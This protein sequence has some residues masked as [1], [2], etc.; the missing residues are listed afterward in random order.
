MHQVSEIFDKIGFGREKIEKV[1]RFREKNGTT[2]T[3]LV[4]LNDETDRI[5]MS[6]AE[7]RIKETA[8][9]HKTFINPDLSQTEREF[10]KNLEQNGTG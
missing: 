8:G 3:V 10:E 2:A 6:A 4:R 5:K 7:N 9:L 1:R